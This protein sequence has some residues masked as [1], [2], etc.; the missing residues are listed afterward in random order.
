MSREYRI[1]VEGGDNWMNTATKKDKAEYEVELT[2]II[3]TL[4]PS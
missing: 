2:F 4:N 3:I 1:L